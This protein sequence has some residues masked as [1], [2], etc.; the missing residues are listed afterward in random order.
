MS[1]ETIL[2]TL[3]NGIATITLNRPETLNAFNDQMIAETTDAFKQAARDKTVRCVVLTGSGRGFSAGQ[4]L[5][6]VQQRS[7]NISVGDHLRH[8]YNKLVERMITLEKPIIGS[9]NGV[10]A[11]AGCSVALATDF[12]IASDKASFIQAFSKVGLIP[13]S[14]STWMLPRLIGYPR[15]YQM[16]ITADKVPAQTALEWGLVNEVVPADQLPEITLAWATRLASGPTLA[17]GLTKRA[18]WASW[19]RSLV[20]SLE[21]E[22]Q[23]QD[24]AVRSHDTLEGI[25]AFIEKRPAQYR[26]E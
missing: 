6:D 11:G 17:F 3:Q 25:A 22:A 14:G 24:I 20:E 16:A 1:Y 4:D 5:K 13:D 8:G 12:R 18:M 9:I 2:F 23:L 15:A 21:Y 10:A 26:G 7:G 19:G